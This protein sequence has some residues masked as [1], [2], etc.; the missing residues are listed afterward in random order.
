MEAIIPILLLA[1]ANNLVVRRS[2]ARSDTD[3]VWPRGYV[4]RSAAM[5]SAACAAASRAIG[6]RYGLH[7]T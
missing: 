5:P 1:L 7:D 2:P 3:H 6:T 4:V